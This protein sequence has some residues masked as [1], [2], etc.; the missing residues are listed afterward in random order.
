MIGHYLHRAHPPVRIAN[1][2]VYHP[3]LRVVVVTHHRYA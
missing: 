2:R 1:E 3:R